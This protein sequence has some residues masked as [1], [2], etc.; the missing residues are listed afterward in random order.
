ML[1][2]PGCCRYRFLIRREVGALPASQD[3]CQQQQQPSENLHTDAGSKGGKHFFLF[4]AY[5][6]FYM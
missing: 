2:F 5:I 1:F 3:V 6:Y 4:Y